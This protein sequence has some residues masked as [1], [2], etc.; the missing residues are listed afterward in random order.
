[1]SLPFGFREDYHEWVVFMMGQPITR[2]RKWPMRG[3]VAIPAFNEERTLANVLDQVLEQRVDVL[4]VN[5]GS[6]DRTR[7]VC[8]GF[9]IAVVSHPTN[10]GYGAAL[11][12]AFEYGIDQG[13]DTVVTF[14][15]DGQHDANLIASFIDRSAKVDIVSGTRYATDFA[16]NTDAPADRRRINGFVTDHLNAVLGLNLTD[17]FCGFKAHR[18]DALRRLRLTENGY[19]MPMEFWVQVACQKLSLEELPVPRVYLPEANRSF[20]AEL[21]EANRRLAYYLSVFDRALEVAR[22]RRDCGF[23]QPISS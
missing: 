17:A 9:P 2:E 6:K 18:T 15:S 19:A 22:R 5:D 11:R 21:D 4:V 13:Y 14:D 8:Q 10:L 20:G 7:E 12:T 23:S 16:T 1:M 3:L